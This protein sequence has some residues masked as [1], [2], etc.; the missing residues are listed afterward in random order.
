MRPTKSAAE[1]RRRMKVHRARLAALGVPA[2]ALEKM[3]ADELRA[4]LRRPKKTVKRFASAS[5]TK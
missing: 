3:Q 4:L 5:P 1:R 2:E